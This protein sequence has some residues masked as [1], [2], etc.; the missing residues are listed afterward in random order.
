MFGRN[1]Q[2]KGLCAQQPCD[3]TGGRSIEFH[4]LSLVQGAYSHVLEANTCT[5]Y[6]CQ[7]TQSYDTGCLAVYTRY[8]YVYEM[9]VLAR[10]L[11][12]N[13]NFSRVMSAEST[14]RVRDWLHT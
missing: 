2:L 1:R 4:I 5:I 9:H 12:S 11:N 13:V 8:I 10:D 6:A 14:L 3:W 7:L